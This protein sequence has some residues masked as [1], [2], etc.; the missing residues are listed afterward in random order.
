MNSEDMAAVA[1]EDHAAV[2]DAAG[3]TTTAA[4]MIEETE[5]INF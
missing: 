4:V 3:M 2:S 1:V 5:T